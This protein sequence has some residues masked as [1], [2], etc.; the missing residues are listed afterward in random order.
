M[1]WLL[2]VAVASLTS[3]LLLSL[4]YFYLYTQDRQRYLAIWCASWA[5]YSIRFC[6]LILVF[7]FG[8]NKVLDLGYYEFNL[9]GGPL[10][11]WG[12][13]MFLGR[14]MSKV[15]LLST[16]LLALWIPI[17]I[18]KDFSFFSLT[19]PAFTFLA[20][21]YIW[22]GIA[23]LR[24]QNLQGL[25]KYFVGWIFIIWGIHKGDYPLLRQVTWFAPWG[26]SLGES[27]ALMAAIGMLLIYFEKVKAELLVNQ[28]K[29]QESE[30]RF[31]SIYNNIG[32]GISLI[33]MDMGII[34]INPQ[35][36]KWFPHIDCNQHHICYRS[37]NTP[38]GD[39]VCSYCPTV[40]TLKDGQV[41]RAI[42][43]TPTENGL[44]YYEV[45]S[46][47]L[48]AADGSIAA[49][50]EMVEDITD[51]KRAEEEVKLLKHSI[52]LHYDGA[53]WLDSDNKFVY[54][55][56]AG[57]KA[58]G[59]K[60]EELIGKT[61]YEVNPM[62]SA[63]GMKEV[64][65]ELRQGGYFSSESLHRR[66]DGSEFPVELVTTY[67]RFDGKEYACGFARDI[68]ERRKLENQL[69]QANK[70]EAIGQLAG[71]VAHDFN[72]ILSAIIGYGHLSLMK[73]R[74]DDPVKLYID[75]ILQS[76]DRAAA[77]TQSLLAFSRKQPTNKELHDFNA[78]IRNFEKFLHRL[79]REDIEMTIQYSVEQPV[80]MADRGQVEQV[81]MNLVTNA[82][83]AI[84]GRGKLTIDTKVSTIDE[85]FIRSHGYGKAGDYAVLSVS[86]TGVGMNEETKKRIFEPF[87][88]TKEV[89]KG[90][91]LGLATVYGIVKA[92]DG[93]INVYS[94]PGKGSIFHIYFPLSKTT[95]A[96]LEP[97]GQNRVLLKGG[98]E[99]ILL[100]EDDASL[101][102]LTSVVLRDMG[103]TVIEAEDGNTAVVRFSE[104]R[105]AIKLVILDGIMPKMNGLEVYL[106]ISALSPNIR[107]IFMSGYS[108]EVFSQDGLP[109]GTEFLPK[110]VKPSELLS[111]V[112]EMLDRE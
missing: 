84:P 35:M 68:T 46:T 96:V 30:E 53:Y 100:T 111:K 107:C 5:L 38:P 99:T 55:N 57:C 66:K 64:W 87:F 31:H 105:A 27:F 60:R 59:Y 75:Q 26:Y 88:T 102:N 14:G 63:E 106:K 41:H 54:V 101:R 11:V 21:I 80:I 1:N 104:N 39:S 71:G 69:L 51:R 9:L 89:G 77:L 44:R 19:F 85:A 10:L 58:L 28:D 79:L 13:S 15:W 67:V 74:D 34:S 83:D 40:Q 108:G 70:M 6:F 12:V 16:S 72:N 23:F 92:H 48:L 52:D 81:I 8:K 98:S 24:T 97:A 33:G 94:E 82:C 50:I 2:P 73:L 91:G 65:E 78:L 32:V 47:P 93:F 49:A 90:T 110:P 17:A 61:L 3:T 42:T 109:T 95:N 56:D 20:I 18:W 86:D 103:Y 25:G 43:E 22:T 7:L 45:I 4:V 76:S 112:R 36:Q 37:F 29:L 62:A